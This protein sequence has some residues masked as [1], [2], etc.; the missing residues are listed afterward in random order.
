[1]RRGAGRRVTEGASPARV[2]ELIPYGLYVVGSLNGDVPMAMVANWLT[3]VSF[4]PPCVAMAVEADSRMRACIGA[5][6]VFSVNLLPKGARETAKAFLKSPEA[7][8]TT[9]GGR[10]YVRAGNGA[11]FLTEAIASIACSV[12]HAMDVPDH[13]LLVGRVVE[14][15]LHR[16]GED[17]LTLRETGWR[18]Q[19]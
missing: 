12:L 17:V 3:Q 5:S 10:P 9:I 18:Y 7:A 1:V 14:A 2:L 15:V 16:E 13:V 11:P 6:G 4:D 8:G 19:K